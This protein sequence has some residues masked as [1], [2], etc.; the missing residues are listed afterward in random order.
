MIYR[1]VNVKYFTVINGKLK[2]SKTEQL[3]VPPQ[4][5]GVKGIKFTSSK[6]YV[7]EGDEVKLELLHRPQKATTT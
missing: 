2:I 6:L 7:N 5:F 1:I 4:L 3:V